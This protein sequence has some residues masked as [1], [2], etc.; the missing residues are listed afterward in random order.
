[1][2]RG[3][4]HS[5]ELGR[6]AF[7]LVEILV[8]M[9]LL[10]VII[11]GLMAMFHQTQ[12]AFR[13]GMT[14]TD[15]LESGRIVTD[16]MVRELEQ[17]TPSGLNGANFNSGNFYSALINGGSSPYATPTVYRPFLQPLPG[18]NQQR[19]NLLDDVFFIIR[20]NQTWTGIGYFVRTNAAFTG[21]WE[22]VGTLYRFETN[23]S[24]MDFS[25]PPVAASSFF[26]GYKTAVLPGPTAP[27]GIRV[28]KI[29]DGVVHFRVRAYD[30][31]GNWINPNIPIPFNPV[32]T[33]I[34]FNY[35]LAT[36]ANPPYEANYYFYSNAVPAFVE[37]E[38][39]ILEQQTLERYRSIPV[40][41]EQTN[42]LAHQAAHVHL[43]R[44]RIAIRNL[45]PSAYQ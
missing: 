1:L 18:G 21:G 43:F 34:L 2:S 9:G 28:S 13:L 42:F 29:L 39:G 17:M 19:T 27:P 11:L 37:L 6:R 8:V 26:Y 3:G 24:V 25:I 44:Q 36:S 41:T 16:M 32:S 4:G 7:S 45:D 31:N 33:N 22:P 20:Q 35:T 5:T 15:V 14:Q 30:I 38:L 12:R 10:T 23:A 40:Y